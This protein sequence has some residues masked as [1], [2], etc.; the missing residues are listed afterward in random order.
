VTPITDEVSVDALRGGEMLSLA[1]HTLHLL[2]LM[3]VFKRGSADETACGGRHDVRVL[4][5]WRIKISAGY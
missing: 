1:E 3:E 2:W 5:V 4:K